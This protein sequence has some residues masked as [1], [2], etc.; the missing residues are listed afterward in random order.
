MVKHTHLI[1]GSRSNIL[2][3]T[4][5]LTSMSDY[6]AFNAVWDEWVCVAINL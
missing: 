3:A 2:M 4:I 1:V 5:Y 6:A